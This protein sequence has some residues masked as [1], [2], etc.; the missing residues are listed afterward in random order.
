M[1]E[2]NKDITI[3]EYEEPI[4]QEVN[5]FDEDNIYNNKNSKLFDGEEL[6]DY[7][8]NMFA[9]LIKV[10]DASIQKDSTERL[11]IDLAD[12]KVRYNKCN[13]FSNAVT[14]KIQEASY[15]LMC[16]YLE[17]NNIEKAKDF[18][19]NFDS[20]ME[21]YIV[22]RIRMDIPN[23]VE[24]ENY[25][26]AM[27]KIDISERVNIEVNSLKF[28]EGILNIEK[29][30]LNYRL[31]I[32]WQPDTTSL[33]VKPKGFLGLY[34]NSYNYFGFIKVFKIRYS[35]RSAKNKMNLS[36][37]QKLREYLIKPRVTKHIRIIF[38]E[39]I[40]NVYLDLEN[41]N[42]FCDFSVKLPS[43]AK[44]I[45]GNLFR[46]NVNISKVDLSNTKIEVIDDY[47]FSNSSL[48]KIKVPMNLRII[49]SSAFANCRDLKKLDF[50]GTNLEYINRNAFYN[51]GIKKIKLS[52]RLSS[53]ELEAFGKCE[54]LKKLDLSSTSITKIDSGFLANSGL[55]KIKLPEEVSTIDFGAFSDCKDLLELDLSNTN[56]KKI[57]AY[58][59]YNSN[60]ESVKLPKTVE[61]IDYQAFAKC[62]N[63]RK[64]DFSK[65]RLKNISAYAFYN[66]GITEL[67][68]P[69][70]KVEVDEVAFKKCYNLKNIK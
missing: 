3:K 65:T 23:V 4:T 50:S 8:K 57:G 64:L 53:I 54:N 36:D 13:V 17:T 22:N 30:A 43:T 41:V 63:L 19:E 16:K 24:Y 26:A 59:F 60:I 46:E 15:I 47:T 10:L 68:M 66:S 27:L 9:M 58:A 20:D 32:E 5:D 62:S 18:C 28:W 2:E 45:G 52:D 39:G 56:I 6:D 44:T 35:P 12:V 49:G 1:E 70:E 33:V 29:P 21:E 11:E 69:K 31:P 40:E 48:K 14:S 55:K 61:S 7:H 42:M 38:E 67:K 25:Y 34:R 51:S 37:V